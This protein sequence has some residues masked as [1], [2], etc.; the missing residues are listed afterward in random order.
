MEPTSRNGLW[1]HAVELGPGAVVGVLP[2]AVRR[3]EV[4]KHLIL[5][6]AIPIGEEERLG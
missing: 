2:E 6:G 5:S 4:D 1:T 3:T